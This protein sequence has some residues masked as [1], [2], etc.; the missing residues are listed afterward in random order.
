ML[1]KLIKHEF[2]A[3]WKYFFL[4]DAITLFVGLVAG[5][6][7]FGISGNFDNLP[8]TLVIMLIFFRLSRMTS[9]VSFGPKLMN[10]LIW[11][12]AE[13]LTFVCMVF[14]MSKIKLLGINSGTQ[15]HSLL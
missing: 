6:I 15:M 12:N 14:T 10:L 4:I 2:V 8:D 11:I 3:T 1:G 9:M 5:F 7:T 13:R